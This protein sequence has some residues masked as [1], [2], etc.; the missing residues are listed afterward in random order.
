MSPAL[1]GLAATGCLLVGLRGFAMVRDPG[2]VRR[3]DASSVGDR[4]DRPGPTTRLLDWLGERFGPRLYKL[5]GSR[6][7]EKVRS[8]LEKA[9]NPGGMTVDRYIYRKAAFVI[10]GGGLGLLLI[11]GG[12]LLPALPFLFL[13]WF[14][15][16]IW[17]SRQ[18]RLR[19]EQLERQLPDFLDIFA[20]SVRAG[21]SYRRG[22]ERV[23]AEMGGPVGEEMLKMLRQMDLG[24]ERRVALAALRDRNESEALEQFTTAQIQAE[25]LGT[26]LADALE[27]LSRDMRRHAY[28]TARR[29]AARAAPRVSLLVTTFIVP[30]AIIL[31]IVG[32]IIGSDVNPGEFLG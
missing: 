10:L 6:R 3:L 16:D 17:L 4:V 23:G 31:I 22:L 9:G 27:T 20:I 13:A 12:N 21:L 26:P 7:R 30:G 29:R 5:L 2:S 15:I 19:Q 18:R 1:I 28:Q 8:E 32:L 11:L 25:E 14:G 24:S